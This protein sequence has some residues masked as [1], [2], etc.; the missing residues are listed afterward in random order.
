MKI[1]KAKKKDFKKMQEIIYDCINVVKIPQKLKDIL[2]KDYTIEKINES[3]KKSEM[4]VLENNNKIYATGRLEPSREIRMIYVSP[5]VHRKG[6]G[7]EM[8]K[9]LEKIA[10]EKN[11]RSVFLHALPT[12]TGF[13][14]KLSY[15][16]MKNDL[17][18]TKKMGKKL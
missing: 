3:H 15:K 10:K 4:F 6:F 18:Y 7:T 12:A 1:R 16:K 11:H 17:K 14:K 13:Y 5:K 2:T 9:Y 8:M